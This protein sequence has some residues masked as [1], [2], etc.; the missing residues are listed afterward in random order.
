MMSVENKQSQ[1]DKARNIGTS[2]PK[3]RWD[4]FSSG[5]NRVSKTKASRGSKGD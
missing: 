4:R 5:G 1:L 2:D 3:A